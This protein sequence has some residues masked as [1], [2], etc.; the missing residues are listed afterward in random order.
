MRIFW[1]GHMAKLIIIDQA[2]LAQFLSKEES[3]DRYCKQLEA[4]NILFL[5]FVPF[6][7]P[8]EDL[9]FLLRQRQIG[10]KNHKNIAYKPKTHS[11][12][13]AVQI[14]EKDA[15]HLL[16]V[17]QRYSHS[18]HA[19]LSKLL[20]PY[21][22]HWS[23]DYASFRPIQEKGRDLRTRAR[24]DLLHVDS[25]PTRPMNGNRILRFFTNINPAEDRKWMTTD[26][27]DTL[28]MRFGGKDVPFPRKD[29]V[30]RLLLK[31]GKQIG[32]PLKVRSA[33]D[34]FMLNL[35]NFLK[36]NAEFQTTCPKDFWDF[37]PQSCWVVFTDQV[38]HAAIA[39]Q[40]A[41]EQTFIVSHH[42]LIDPRTS[43]LAV[44]EKLAQAAMV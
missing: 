37:P 10:A 11:I 40:Y 42:T 43:P 12:S 27:F 26:S 15:Q 44:L 20:V 29:S 16:E 35:H 33:Y 14:S 32:L 39:G 7:F 36:E 2:E 18:A 4:G 5:P 41:L 30:K 3:R 28:A 24:N 31:A 38:S 17:M 23:L 9:Q 21:A 8:Q 22:V 25:F 6:T 34:E 13:N 19:F 1:W